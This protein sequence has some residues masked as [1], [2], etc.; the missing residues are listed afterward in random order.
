MTQGTAEDCSDRFAFRVQEHGAAVH[1][2][3]ERG[4]QQL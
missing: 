3:L 4:K 2:K 1:L